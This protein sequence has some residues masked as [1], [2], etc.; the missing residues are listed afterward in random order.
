MVFSI[1]ASAIPFRL[2]REV[3]RPSLIRPSKDTDLMPK[4]A[5]ALRLV[6]SLVTRYSLFIVHC[7][8][9]L[10]KV[11]HRGITTLYNIGWIPFDASL[12]DLLRIPPDSRDF[13]PL[14]IRRGLG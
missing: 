4:R 7:S 6:S 14:Y 10:L 9:I 11:K 3:L 2:A 1:Q 13:I 12:R 8:L 5:P